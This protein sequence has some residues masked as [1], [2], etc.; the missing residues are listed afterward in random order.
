MLLFMEQ[1][2]DRGLDLRLQRFDE[3]GRPA[4]EPEDVVAS[5]LGDQHGTFSPD[6]RFILYGSRESGDNQI[7][8]RSVDGTGRW[9]V[10]DNGGRTPRWSADGKKIFYH[11]SDPDA[12]EIKVVEFAL[13]NGTPSFGR[14]QTYLEARLP[15]VQSVSAS[16]DIHPADGRVIALDAAWDRGERVNPILVQGWFDELK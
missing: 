13:E 15:L 1:T 5:P 2:Q 10:S 7:Y 4:G 8:V 16:F 3:N 9:Q 11:H 14:P 12:S 6:D